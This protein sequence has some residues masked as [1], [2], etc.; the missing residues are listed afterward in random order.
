MVCR[1]LRHALLLCAL[2]AL[3][4]SACAR[5]SDGAQQPTRVTLSG[6]G[7]TPQQIDEQAKLPTVPASTT[8][9]TEPDLPP[10]TDPR[11]FMVGDSVLLAT[12]QGSPDALDTYVGSLGWQ[13]T[14]DARV[15]R[16]T[17][18]G[19]RVL[20]NR[21]DEVHEVA[22]VV[23]GNNY[24]GDETQFAAEVEGILE[25][26]DGVKVIVWLTVPV[27]DDKQQEVNLILRAAEAVDERLVVVDWEGYTRV[28]PR[29]LR[30]DGIHP[31]TFGA[32]V[33][34]QL[35]GVTLGR[36]PGADPNLPLPIVGSSDRPP[37]AVAVNKGESRPSEGS[38]QTGT[39]RPSNTTTPR[40]PAGTTT[41]RPPGTT[42][43]TTTPPATSAPAPTD[44]PTPTDPPPSDSTADPPPEANASAT[45][46]PGT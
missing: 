46:A 2:G 21:R 4:A 36:A 42:T 1:P 40:R 5:S 44:P 10:L 17:D 8:T 45:T 3:L 15:S 29:V 26:L 38:N 7:V 19:L 22:V 12:T 24:G 30:D 9:T 32:D 20:R 14:V 35:I 27:Y 6:I 11:V 41:T 13:I 31:S 37:G 33:I 18:E 16:F 34:A 25:T 43:A 23:L 39:T 28:D